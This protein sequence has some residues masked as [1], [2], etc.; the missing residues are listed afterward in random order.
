[1]ST[2]RLTVTVVPASLCSALLQ[3]ITTP[4]ARGTY[5]LNLTYVHADIQTLLSQR[6][7]EIDDAVPSL[8]AGTLM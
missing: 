8:G 3:L 5:R 6:N 7:C 2:H 1:M 4:F